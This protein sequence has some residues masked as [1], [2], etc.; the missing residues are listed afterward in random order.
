MHLSKAL[1][2]Y[3][4][5]YNRFDP[6]EF[7]SLY[8]CNEVV[9]RIHHKLGANEDFIASFQGHLI[10]G[11]RGFY[12]EGFA[13]TDER[14]K[15]LNEVV[16][17]KW[18]ELGLVKQKWD[19]NRSAVVE[20]GKD[21]LLKLDRGAS[22]FLGVEAPGVFL[23]AYENNSA[24][25]EKINIWV[26]KRSKRVKRF[27]EMLDVFAGGGIASGTSVWDTLCEE[28]Q[29]ETG[30]PIELTQL[31]KPAGK[32]CTIAPKEKSGSQTE[33]MWVYTLDLSE[34]ANH[35]PKI[36]EQIEEFKK[37]LSQSNPSQDFSPEVECFQLTPVSELTQ[38]F[39][40]KKFKDNI[41]PAYAVALISL[42]VISK[43]D[44]YY[45]ELMQRLDIQP[46]NQTGHVVQPAPLPQ[47]HI[48][49]G[50]DGKTP[51]IPRPHSERSRS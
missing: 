16:V 21:V 5:S 18:I 48:A 42:G 35:S 28:V 14:T 7:T 9:G 22:H 47:Q 24:D 45:Q 13:T 12:L 49:P 51:T 31:A 34:N 32:A 4:H 10:R 11:E 6:N 30:L 46:I 8:I 26:A 2:D 41:A 40:E 17:P 43:S 29:S 36:K 38:L 23:V 20:S 39:A 33:P 50:K 44:P 3:V 25:P 15:F 27:P 19:E 37:R 1:L